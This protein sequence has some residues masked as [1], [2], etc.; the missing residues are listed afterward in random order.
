MDKFAVQ[1]PILAHAFPHSFQE[2]GHEI[3]D[4][5]F[6]FGFVGGCASGEFGLMKSIFITA[7]TLR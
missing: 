6:P 4:I 7:A 2:T 3:M 1:T 5:K